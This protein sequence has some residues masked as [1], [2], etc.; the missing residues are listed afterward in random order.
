MWSDSGKLWLY[1]L[2][3]Q[4]VCASDDEIRAANREIVRIVEVYPDLLAAC[5]AAYDLLVGWH[6]QHPDDYEKKQE[7]IRQLSEVLGEVR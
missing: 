7:V 5:E 1:D 3:V 4:P 2:Q 6:P